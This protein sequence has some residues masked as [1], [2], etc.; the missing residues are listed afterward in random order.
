MTTIETRATYEARERAGDA[1]QTMTSAEYR[2]L[3]GTPK[4]NKNKY[5]NVRCESNDGKLFDS[6]AE[7]NRYHVLYNLQAGG[8]ISDLVCQPVKEIQPAY[9]RRG[10]KIQAITYRADFGYTENGRRVIEDV[11]GGKATRTALFNVKWKIAKYH[12]PDIVFR[13]VEG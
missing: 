7:R 1:P 6:K 10:K 5:G 3:M 4:R 12:Y 8:E 2:A 11:K 9:K 13:I